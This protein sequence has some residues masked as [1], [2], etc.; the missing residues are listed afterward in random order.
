MKNF[1]QWLATEIIG[2]VNVAFFILKAVTVC[3]TWNLLIVI[4]ASSFIK[5]E[6]TNIQSFYLPVFSWYFPFLIF[7]LA[8]F[9]EVMFRLLPIYFILT[10]DLDKY[11]LH[12]IIISSIVFGYIHGSALNILTQGFTGMILSI[13]FLK[14]GG[15]F[16]DFAKGTLSSTFAHVIFNLV[17][18]YSVYFGMKVF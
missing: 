7:S 11:I 6:S 3:L 4:F 2:P 14:C 13:V 10:R 5:I 16:E 17:I 18:I 12:A 1:R 9:E 8:L 15:F